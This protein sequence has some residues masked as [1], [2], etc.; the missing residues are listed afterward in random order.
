MY[1]TN[2]L[3]GTA[4]RIQASTKQ[5]RAWIHR[6][7]T[8]FAERLTNDHV[9]CLIQCSICLTCFIKSFDSY[10]YCSRDTRFESRLGTDSL[11]WCFRASFI[12]F[13]KMFSGDTENHFYPF[14]QHG[15]YNG[16]SRWMQGLLSN[17]AALFEDTVKVTRRVFELARNFLPHRTHIQQSSYHSSLTLCRRW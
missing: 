4:V 12:S 2:V 16:I 13:C 11:D 5:R 17:Q 3:V 7:N 15:I 6:H 1:I 8:R 14:P 9:I 10:H